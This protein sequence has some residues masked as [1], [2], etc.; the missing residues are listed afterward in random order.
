MQFAFNQRWF[1]F[2]F[3]GSGGG[4]ETRRLFW[5]FL[6]VLPGLV[7]GGGAQGASEFGVLCR[8]V[9]DILEGGTQVSCACPKVGLGCR[10]HPAWRV[11]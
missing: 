7:S 9:V 11:S 4:E 8:A 5:G 1:F 3:G 2:F 6:L 10:R